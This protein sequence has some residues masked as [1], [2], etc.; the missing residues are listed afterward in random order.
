MFRVPTSFQSSLLPRQRLSASYLSLSKVAGTARNATD[1]DVLTRRLHTSA[2]KNLLIGNDTRV[3]YQGFTGKQATANAKQS[4]AWGTKVVGGVTPGKSGEH[5]GL[6]LFS[7][8]KTAAEKLKP[9]AT[10]IFAPAKTVAAAIEEAIE[11]EIGLIVAVAE[12]VP[13]HDMLRV[14]F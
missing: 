1:K 12:H 14:N 7:D 9:D 2:E 6:P 3:I 11:A 8:V 13:L 5:L 4:I 10:A